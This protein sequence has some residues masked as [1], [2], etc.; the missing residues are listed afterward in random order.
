M[1]VDASQTV[2]VGDRHLSGR[3]SCATGERKLV[4]VLGSDDEPLFLTDPGA[5]DDRLEGTVAAWQRRSELLPEAGRP[6]G[7]AMRRSALVLET[8][9]SEDDGAFAAAAT[10]SLPERIGGP[11]NYDYRFAWVRDSSFAV[12]ALIHLGLHEEVHRSVSWLLRALRRSAPELQIFYRLD[13]TVPDRE[14]E[15]DLPGYRGSRPVRSGN[16]ASGQQ[17]LGVFGD[18]FDSI[19]RY[20]E[21]GH[22]LDPASG[23]LLAQLADRCCEQWPATDSGIWE[24]EVHR[25]YTISKIGCWVALDRACR[26]AA[27]GAMPAS[28]SERWAMEAAEV[29]KFVEQHCWSEEKRSYTFYAGTDQLDAAV[30]LAGRTGFD[31]GPRLAATVDAVQ[32]ELGR[33]PTVYRYTGMEHEEGAFVA[34]SFW[35]VDALARVGR[36]DEAEELMSAAAGLANPVGLLAEQ[37]DPVTGSLLGNFPQGLS[38]LALVNAAHTLEKARGSRR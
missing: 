7:L 16:S 1:V 15:L 32:A 4:A 8:L 37:V 27:S 23:A 5:V 24:L 6:F 11:K 10:T 38:H 29:R 20:V 35:L 21:A 17:Q 2:D 12:D 30:L 36:C 31:R 28:S 25:H 19:Y 18:L 26:L 22:V 34:C 33:G 3:L 13:G 9:L 14:S